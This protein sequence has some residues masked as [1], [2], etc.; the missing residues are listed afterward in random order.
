M[1]KKPNNRLLAATEQNK[2]LKKRVEQL[3]NELAHLIEQEA[4]Y[5]ITWGLSK[6]GEQI[7]S[8]V[9][10]TLSMQ[11]AE[12]RGEKFDGESLK[13]LEYASHD[14]VPQYPNHAHEALRYF[15]IWGDT[16]V[17]SDATAI[18]MIADYF[19]KKRKEASGEP[20]P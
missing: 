6:M 14:Y 18:R 3:E 11:L 19:K 15:G 12:A 5:R 4:K 20:K 1:N 13:S 7:A 2:I 10:I 9:I 17:L 16:D 8:Q